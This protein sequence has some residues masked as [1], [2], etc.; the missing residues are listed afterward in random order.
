MVQQVDLFQTQPFRFWYT[1]ICE[2]PTSNTCR[3]PDKKDFNAQVG[4]FDTSGA[5]SGLIDE[6]GCSVSD[7]KVPE[8]VGSDGEGHGFGTDL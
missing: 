5:R 3:A 6:V 4:C 1:E 7:T 8:P 2:N